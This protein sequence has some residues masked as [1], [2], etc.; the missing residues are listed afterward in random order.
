MFLIS[1]CFRNKVS[2]KTIRS[3]HSKSKNVVSKNRRR[4]EIN[5]IAYFVCADVSF[6]EDNVLARK[7]ASFL[8]DNLTARKELVELSANL[9]DEKDEMMIA[10]F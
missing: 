9:I 1:R 5:T 4:D 10:H 2:D 3:K 6:F 8:E 7:E